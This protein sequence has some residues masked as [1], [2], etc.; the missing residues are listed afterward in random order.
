MNFEMV[1]GAVLGIALFSYFA[2]ALLHI[3]E[4]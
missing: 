2:Y 4:L 1:A 3:E